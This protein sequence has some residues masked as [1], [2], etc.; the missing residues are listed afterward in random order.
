MCSLF[1]TLNFPFF[2]FPDTFWLQLFL[3]LFSFDFFGN[4]LFLTC[5]RFFTCSDTLSFWHFSVLT[6]SEFPVFDTQFLMLSGLGQNQVLP[7]S[8][9]D[10][11]TFPNLLLTPD[12]AYGVVEV[13]IYFSRAER[14]Q[15]QF[16]LHYSSFHNFLP[17]GSKIGCDFFI[18][19]S[20][21]G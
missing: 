19:S 20:N 6:F 11:S 12:L 9:S 21:N 5:S 14:K 17:G 13:D 3:T 2:T 7:L 15:E 1:L 8:M 4:F 18:L 10:T 16:N